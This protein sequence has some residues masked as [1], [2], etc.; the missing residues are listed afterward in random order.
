VPRFT[1]LLIYHSLAEEETFLHNCHVVILRSVI[2]NAHSKSCIKLCYNA[3]LQ[4]SKLSDASV[5]AG[6]RVSVVG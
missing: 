5:A 1:I 2:E 3:S 6:A 4:D